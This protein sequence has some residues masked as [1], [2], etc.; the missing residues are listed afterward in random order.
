MKNKSVIHEKHIKYTCPYYMHPSFQHVQI[1][2]Q[3]FRQISKQPNKQQ[4]KKKKKL[5]ITS[6]TSHRTHET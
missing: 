2:Q 5:F 1:L 6:C 4:Q 3:T